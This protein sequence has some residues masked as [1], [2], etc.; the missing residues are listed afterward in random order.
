KTFGPA[1]PEL[2]RAL[3]NL[4]LVYANLERE[5]EARRLFER[6]LAIDE[7]TLEPGHP[8]LLRAQDLLATHCSEDHG[9][10]D[11]ESRELC[12]RHGM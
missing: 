4:G 3:L 5:A 7:K 10:D 9:L 8:Q 6:S 11:A 1:H 2:A 12:R